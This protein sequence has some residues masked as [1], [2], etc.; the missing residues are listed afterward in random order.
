MGK[1]FFFGRHGTMKT[2]IDLTGKTWQEVVA[3]VNCSKTT[4]KN[5]L[6]RG[7]YVVDHRKRTCVP[8]PID[9]EGGYK[10]AWFTFERFFRH[11][12]PW[13]LSP[14]DLVQ[15]ALLRLVELGGH[16]RAG[17]GRFMFYTCRNAMRA[18]ITKYGRSADLG[19]WRTIRQR[20]YEEH[21]ER[22]RGSSGRPDTWRRSQRATEKIVR[23][24]YEL[25]EGV[26]QA[27]L[28][29]HLGINSGD[30]SKK[31]NKAIDQGLVE[32]LGHAKGRKGHALRVTA[33]GRAIIGA[34]R[35]AA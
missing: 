17:E 15:E 23:A 7:Y 24:I 2:R 13:N 1:N 33:W 14:E 22:R 11:R 4:A 35:L 25:G 31:M 29:R 20:S 32:N 19:D 30:V 6:K 18:Y 5:A 27:Q 8:G 10:M 26:T 21:S 12:C 28:R 16:P 34:P 9:A 3:L